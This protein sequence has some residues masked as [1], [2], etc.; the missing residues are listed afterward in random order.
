[1]ATETE[2]NFLKSIDKALKPLYNINTEKERRSK[3]EY[4][5]K[6]ADGV[7]SAWQTDYD[8][9]VE[10]AKWWNECTWHSCEI[11]SRKVVED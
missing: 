1:M 9:I 4:R 10:S 8:D 11:E 7:C 2:K 6:F 5:L 3:M